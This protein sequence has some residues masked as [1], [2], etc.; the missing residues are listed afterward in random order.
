VL[1]ALCLIAIAAAAVVR[2]VHASSYFFLFDDYAL[3][4]QAS[5][6]PLRD[7]VATPLFGFY[8]PGL[9]LVM[10]L[11][12]G[13]FGWHAPPGYAAL[14][15]LV[16]AVNTVL[17]ATLA[18]RL[19]GSRV[20]AWTAAALFFIG[21]WSA[22]AIFWVSG[23]FDVLATF[24]VL[25]ALQAGAAF[26]QP[27]PSPRPGIDVALA[28]TVLAG[29]VVAVFSKESAVVLPGLA[30][31]L[32]APPRLTAWRR[33][34]GMVAVT[35]LAAVTYLVIR[36]AVLSSMGGVYGDWLTL[37]AGAPILD[38]LAGF[39]RASVAWPA[40]HDA[41]MRPVGVMAFTSVL[42]S[43]CLVLLVAAASRRPA[44]AARL[45][46]ALA[47]TVLPVAWVGL[48]PGSSGGGR[49]LYLPGVPFVL[50]CAVGAQ[51]LLEVRRAGAAVAGVAAT[52]IVLV[53][54]TA[55]L[56]AQRGVWAQACRLS[57]DGIEAFRPFVGGGDAVHIDNLPFWFVEG[58]YVLK[59]YAFGYYYFPA[60]V[61]PV[62]AT[63]LS[64]TSIGG[65]ATITTRGAE[66]GA[67]PAP[68]VARRI[69]LPIGLP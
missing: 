25:V 13:L 14:I 4:G 69:S 23:G 10:R 35:V 55:S 37:I 32:A 52:A 42:S 1:I 61:P 11:A 47:L 53:S 63:A 30:F 6:W 36:R 54:A 48:V 40:P 26:C 44:T 62:S 41:R 9:F 27:R 12:H 5:R 24:G 8:R 38:N 31:A 45:V 68:E 19:A 59:S 39:A 46:A 34:A 66:P 56:E 2:I 3:N 22:E 21:P 17:V 60:P 65:R 28:L 16:H 58:P 50:L 20:A 7:V 33:T 64:L 67:P 57:R 43:A 29:A 51:A 49:V 15:L 18:H